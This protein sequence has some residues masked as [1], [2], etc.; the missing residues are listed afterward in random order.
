PPGAGPAAGSTLRLKGSA[1][2]FLGFADSIYAV[3]MAPGDGFYEALSSSFRGA[4]TC[5]RNDGHG[6][7]PGIAIRRPAASGI[8]RAA[9]AAFILA[10]RTAM[11]SGN[12]TVLRAAMSTC[13]AMFS[14]VADSQP[15]SAWCSSSK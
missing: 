6:H 7:L 2:V 13:S 11:L 14:D 9:C 5:P 12:G 1:K 10:S 8:G 3:K 15:C 4:G